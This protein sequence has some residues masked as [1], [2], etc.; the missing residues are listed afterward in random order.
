MQSVPREQR[1]VLIVTEGRGGGGAAL[2]TV[3]VCLFCKSVKLFYAC[4]LYVRLASGASSWQILF[5]HE[6]GYTAG[7][8][9]LWQHRKICCSVLVHEKGAFVPTPFGED[10]RA[11]GV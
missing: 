5:L 1:E 4:W 10:K 6:C 11:R 8:T 7:E 3:R 2:A 9:E